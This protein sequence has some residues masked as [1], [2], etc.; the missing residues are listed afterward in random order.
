MDFAADTYTFSVDGTLS[1]AFAF[2]AGFASDVLLRESVITYAFPDTATNHR[3]DF[4][5]SYDNLTTTAVVP[6]PTTASLLTF[7]CIALANLR[8]CR[9][10]R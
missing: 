5:A 8:R 3:S 7:C 4:T 9:N 1:S 10:S 2:D 6:E